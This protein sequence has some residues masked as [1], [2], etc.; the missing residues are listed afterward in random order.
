MVPGVLV[1]GYVHVSLVGPVHQNIGAGEGS[2]VA[3][4]EARAPVGCM[5]N[6]Y[7]HGSREQTGKHKAGAK[8]LSKMGEALPVRIGQS[9]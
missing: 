5:A 6:V 3:H 7:M 9:Y 8:G 1:I 4:L 2:K